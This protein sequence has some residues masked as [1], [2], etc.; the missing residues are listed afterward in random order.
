MGFTGKVYGTQSTEKLYNIF[1]LVDVFNHKQRL[2]KLM[3]DLEETN[4]RNKVCTTMYE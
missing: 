3:M 1:G 4:E 2:L